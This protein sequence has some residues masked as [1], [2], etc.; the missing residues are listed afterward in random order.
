MKM[1]VVSWWFLLMIVLLAFALFFSE[2]RNYK[3]SKCSH[4]WKVYR[5]CERC[6]VKMVKTK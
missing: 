4:E 1:D 3:R 6:G 5:F 2:L